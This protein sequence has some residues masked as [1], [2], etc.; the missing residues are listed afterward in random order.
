MVV[1]D[2]KLKRDIKIS[3]KLLKSLGKK[4]RSSNAADS[5]GYAKLWKYLKESWDNFVS[6][7]VHHWLYANKLGVSIYNDQKQFS[8]IFKN[9]NCKGI[10][11]LSGYQVI[12]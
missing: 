3:K 11:M 2:G 8:L 12:L 4:I 1:W 6:S 9:V 10:P 7:M 5:V